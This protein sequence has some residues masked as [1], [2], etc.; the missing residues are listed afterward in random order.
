MIPIIKAD[1][2]SDG[3]IETIAP[4]ISAQWIDGGRLIVIRS[5]TTSEDLYDQW[6]DWMRVLLDHWPIDRSFCVLYDVRDPRFGLS[7]PMG[8]KLRY[9]LAD[10]KQLHMY[11]AILTPNDKQKTA[12]AVVINTIQTYPTQTQKFFTD[13]DAAKDWLRSCFRTDLDG[14]IDRQMPDASDTE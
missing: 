5:Y 7:L 14:Q 2:D 13:V 3:P 11:S 4:K 9:L 8:T 12:I 1:D 6:D 10:Y